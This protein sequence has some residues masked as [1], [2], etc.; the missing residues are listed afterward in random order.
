MAKDYESLS[1]YEVC[2]HQLIKANRIPEIMILEKVFLNFFIFSSVKNYTFRVD[3]PGLEMVGSLTLF[4]QRLTLY[5][6]VGRKSK[7]FEFQYNFI[8]YLI[9]KYFRR[10]DKLTFAMWHSPLIYDSP[11][12]LTRCS[13]GVAYLNWRYKDSFIGSI[14]DVDRNILSTIENQKDSY[15]KQAKIVSKLQR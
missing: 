1:T 15:S 12:N 10:K 13:K 9:I 7:N 3:F 8:F 14:I 4:G 5:F 2:A 6:M 11:W